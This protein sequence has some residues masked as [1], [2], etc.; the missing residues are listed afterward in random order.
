MVN[1]VFLVLWLALGGVANAETEWFC[2]ESASSRSGVVVKVCG[3]GSG[4][5]LENARAAALSQA[6]AEF[7]SLC[8]ESD[9]CRGFAFNVIP[10]RT[11]CEKKP[12][13]VGG[14]VCFRGL[15]YTILEKRDSKQLYDEEIAQLAEREEIL[16]AEMELVREVQV[17]RHRVES[18]EG[19]VETGPLEPKRQGWQLEASASVG[20]SG[21]QNRGTRDIFG[22]TETGTGM[23][24]ALGGAIA[25][26][27][28]RDVQMALRADHG[29]VG[30]SI[31]KVTL[32]VP[33]GGRGSVVAIGPEL[34]HEFG[35]SK[36][37]VSEPNPFWK[38]TDWEGRTHDVE[39]SN[40]FS[41]TSVGLG[42]TLKPF[43]DGAT[44][45]RLGA[46]YPISVSDG[47]DSALAV[48][49]GVSGAVEF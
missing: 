31:T 19:G 39:V 24:F 9:D 4:L 38:G 25:Y 21:I 36:S 1:F 2:R 46:S 48:Y 44:L 18:L 17:R 33:I 32:A 27:I 23:R 49:L 16:R 40:T 41:G 37:T 10:L 6:K 8:K 22:K 14:Y 13:G 29:L 42:L 7:L 47:N 3:V 28:H 15:E 43:R 34:H 11:D 30:P 12:G 5:S 35:S 26:R 45:V 20:G